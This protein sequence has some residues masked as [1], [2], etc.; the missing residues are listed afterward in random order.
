MSRNALLAVFR[1][2]LFFHLHA[3]NGLVFLLSIRL[4][5][6]HVSRQ[7]PSFVIV[8]FM[9]VKVSRFWFLVLGGR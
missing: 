1:F 5:V 4:R 8:G 9:V 2:P 6:G 3:Q 7:F